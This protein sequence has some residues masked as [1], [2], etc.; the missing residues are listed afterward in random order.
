MLTMSPRGWRQRSGLGR[1]GGCGVE[2][3]GW[4]HRAAAQPPVRTRNLPAPGLGLHQPDHE[5]QCVL[6]MRCQ[7]CAFVIAPADKAH[8]PYKPSQLPAEPDGCVNA[9][10]PSAGAAAQPETGGDSADLPLGGRCVDRR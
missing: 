5:E 6:L 7:A 3:P 2:L 8:V 9:L 1:S 10:L 4:D